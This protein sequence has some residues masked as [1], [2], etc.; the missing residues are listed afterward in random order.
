MSDKMKNI[1]QEQLKAANGNEIHIRMEMP[2]DWGVTL[3]GEIDGKDISVQNDF[4]FA[5]FASEYRKTHSTEKVNI[6]DFN[7]DVNGKYSENPRFDEE[8]QKA[9]DALGTLE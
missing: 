3:S 2:Y 8:F 7:L 9:Q 6:I 4:E 1:L 5:K